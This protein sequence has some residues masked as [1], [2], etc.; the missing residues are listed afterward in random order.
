[1]SAGMGERA[2]EEDGSKREEESRRKEV[3]ATF[4]RK[5][6]SLVNPCCTRVSRDC[7]IDSA[8]AV[9]PAIEGD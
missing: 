7:L 1:M 4:I 9:G 2:R 6:D 5:R 3:A 8:A